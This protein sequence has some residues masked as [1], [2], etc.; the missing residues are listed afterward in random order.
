MH[1]SFA[2]RNFIENNKCLT[3][4]LF[5]DGRL[6]AFM[7]G[8]LG[9]KNE[10]VVPRLSIDDEFGFYSPGMLL[11]NEAIKYFIE[12]TKIRHL[13]LSQ[14]DEPYKYKMGGTKHNT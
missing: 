14:G 1:Q 8:L 5:I 13:D 11:V 4:G 9:S 6:A 3:L 12:K 10:Y 2:T 7:S